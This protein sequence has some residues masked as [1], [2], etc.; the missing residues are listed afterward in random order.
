MDIT[1]ENIGNLEKIIEDIKVR[2]CFV[3]SLERSIKLLNKEPLT[4]PPSVKYFGSTNINIPGELREKAYEILWARDND[5]L[6]LPTMILDAIIKVIEFEK[7]VCVSIKNFH[8]FIVSC[9][10]KASFG[11]KYFIDWRYCHG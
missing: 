11:R 2:T 9:R 7:F 1:E 3:T 10:Y 4:P 8:T 5:N 6:S